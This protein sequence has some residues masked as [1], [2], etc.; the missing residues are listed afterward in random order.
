MKQLR[1]PITI[2]CATLF[3][4]GLAAAGNIYKW[5][6]ENG[7]VHYED[8]P[9]GET[10][11]ERV[12]IA[13]RDTD[14]AAVEARLAERRKARATADQVAA[15]ATPEMSREEIRAEQ[16][17]RQEKCEMYRSRLEAFLRS[18]RLYEEGESGERNYLSEDEVLAARS[19]VEEQIRQ[20]C[21]AP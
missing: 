13:T 10:Q 5:V 20:Y 17:A 19:R 12:D 15:E 21:G 3:A 8:R 2:A 7:N 9:V 14:D 11:M 18:T 1:L 6:D 4:W 16:Q